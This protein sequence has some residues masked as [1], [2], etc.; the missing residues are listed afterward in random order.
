[1]TVTDMLDA[2]FVNKNNYYKL[3]SEDKESV[4]F[5][6]NRQFSKKYPLNAYALNNKYGD[7]STKM[8]FQFL[9]F[10]NEK[11]IPKQVF[12]NKSKE[13]EDDVIKKYLEI[14]KFEMEIIKQEILIDGY[15]QDDVKIELLKEMDIIKKVNKN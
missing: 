3:T 15:E 9:F 1:M 5:I 11:Y 2:I 8:D 14:D 7:I 6:L 12:T 4:F 10:K 13:N